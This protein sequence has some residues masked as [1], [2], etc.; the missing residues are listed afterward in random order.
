L[1]FGFW[2]SR[3]FPCHL[4]FVLCPLF[5]LPAPPV[6]QSPELAEVAKEDA[7]CYLLP[8]DL[9]SSDLLITVLLIIDFC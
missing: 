5:L 7:A 4:R 3:A 9:F 6:L 1:A 8:S 2:H